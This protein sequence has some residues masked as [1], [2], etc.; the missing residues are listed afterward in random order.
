[1]NT[2]QLFN[3]TNKPR[4]LDALNEALIRH[5]GYK[6]GMRFCDISLEGNTITLNVTPVGITKNSDAMK[7]FNDMAAILTI[8]G[9]TLEYAIV[10]S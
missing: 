7:A 4:Y 3:E 6:L 8:S 9:S 2:N 1:M 5:P 10:D